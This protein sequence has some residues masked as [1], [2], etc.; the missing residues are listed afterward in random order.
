MENRKGSGIFLGVIG[1]ATLVVAIIGATFAYFSATA[2][3]AVDAV[4]VQSTSLS[5]GFAEAPVLKT[6]LIPAADNIAIYGANNQEGGKQCVD[7]NGNDVCSVYDFTVAN[8]TTTAQQ[9]FTNITIQ[10]NDFENLYF[11]LYDGTTQVIA[12]TPFI[13][14]ESGETPGVSYSTNEQSKVVISL[15]AIT[16]YLA[17]SAT[18]VSDED[19][20]DMSK[21]TLNETQVNGTAASNMK[22][23]RLIVWIHETNKNQTGDTASSFAAGINITTASGNSGVTGVIASA[24]K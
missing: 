6:N 10:T 23:Y 12:P 7:D 3:S 19:K 18:A 8:P 5:L 1:V 11:A 9:I 16:Q 20:N 21:Y 13:K 2:N 17:P 15:D 22:T 14:P 24:G 4:N